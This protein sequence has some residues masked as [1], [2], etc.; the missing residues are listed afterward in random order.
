MKLKEEGEEIREER[1]RESCCVCLRV[2]TTWS[3]VTFVC[4]VKEMYAT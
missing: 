4:M 3:H 2:R 1:V